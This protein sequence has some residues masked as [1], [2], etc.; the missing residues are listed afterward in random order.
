MFAGADLWYNSLSMSFRSLSQLLALSLAASAGRLVAADEAPSSAPGS[1]K[2]AAA[3]PK[4]SSARMARI[5][6]DTTYY[7]RKEGMAVFTGHVHVD[8]A[9]YQMHAEKAYVFMT[10]TNTLKRIVAIGNIALTNEMK[11]AYGAKA[12]YY[13][14]SGMVVLYGG[15]GR[16]AEVI[17]AS[18][19][20][21]QTLRGSKI[22]FW[23]DSEQ[24]EVLDATI[25][26]PTSASGGAA[27]LGGF[28]GVGPSR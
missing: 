17:D 9:Q 22:K 18:K 3:K 21:P 19:G 24:V 25:V 15:D 1:A 16:N 28:P 8:D 7:D 20:Q 26:A 2:V 11:F 27:G 13:K 10:E 6:S 23:I 5:T 12:S 4:P 14:E